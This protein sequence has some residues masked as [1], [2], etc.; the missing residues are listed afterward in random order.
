MM[1]F[2]LTM[3]LNV[4]VLLNFPF[5]IMHTKSVLFTFFSSV[6]KPR[7]KAEAAGRRPYNEKGCSSVKY[8]NILTVHYLVTET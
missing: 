2:F 1:M 3:S 8:N 5:K 4:L 6:V 7:V